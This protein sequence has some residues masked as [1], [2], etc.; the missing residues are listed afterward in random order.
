MTETNIKTN[1]VFVH[2]CSNFVG[3]RFSRYL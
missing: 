3:V 1:I 2:T